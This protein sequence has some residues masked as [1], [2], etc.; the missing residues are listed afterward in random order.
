MD[1][2]YGRAQDLFLKLVAPTGALRLLWRLACL[3]VPRAAVPTYF[4]SAAFFA[5]PCL[6]LLE[7]CPQGG[8]A[9][10]SVCL[11]SPFGSQ[12]SVP[13]TGLRF[14]RKGFVPPGPLGPCGLRL[15]SPTFCGQGPAA[16]L[17][18]RGP[19]PFLGS[20]IL[21]FKAWLGSTHKGSHQP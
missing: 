3:A 16:L 7:G 2:V 10:W 9:L 4:L 12:A 21:S 15:W 17:A 11:P 8:S 5:G 1:A 19:C 6:Y 18:L 13:L 20:S 14:A